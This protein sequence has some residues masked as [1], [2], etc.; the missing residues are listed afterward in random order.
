MIFH[1]ES[2]KVLKNLLSW[3]HK[4]VHVSGWNHF[5]WHRRRGAAREIS[6]EGNGYS[7][8]FVHMSETGEDRCS[9]ALEPF[10]NPEH[11]STVQVCFRLRSPCHA[12]V[13]EFWFYLGLL[14][15]SGL[16]SA[17]SIH[18][19]QIWVVLNLKRDLNENA[20]VKIQ[21][22]LFPHVCT[23]RGGQQPVSLYSNKSF[24]VQENGSIGK[25]WCVKVTNSRCLNILP[26]LFLCSG[27]LIGLLPLNSWGM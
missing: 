10:N 15:I 6:C 20:R 18:S 23:E 12:D 21:V 4:N 26:W 3:N 13:T 2:Y 19:N 8:L 22:S 17:E 24:I 14:V 5:E 16:F 7:L 11:V 1:I 25:P 9:C 27:F